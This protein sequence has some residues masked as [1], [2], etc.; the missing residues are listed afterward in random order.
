M[1]NHQD[2]IR[3]ARKL[4]TKDEEARGVSIFRTKAWEN[5]TEAI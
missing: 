3:L 2:K 4:R 1:T 5:R